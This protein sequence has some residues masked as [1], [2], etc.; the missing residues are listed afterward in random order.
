MTHRNW[1][2]RDGLL[3]KICNYFLS[4][5]FKSREENLTKLLGMFA[6]ISFPFLSMILYTL[7]FSESSYLKVL[8]KTFCHPWSSVTFLSF[9]K[10]HFSPNLT[11]LPFYPQSQCSFILNILI[12]HHKSPKNPPQAVGE[13]SWER[14]EGQS[15]DGS[16]G[17]SQYH[18]HQ[19]EG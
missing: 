14:A 17:Q 18:L 9:N 4:A 12:R 1:S 13:T 19:A 3:K 6:N 2:Q 11:L 10:G 7:T 15:R 16:S 8:H 5:F